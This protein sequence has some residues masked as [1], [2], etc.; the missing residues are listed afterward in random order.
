VICGKQ[1]QTNGIKIKVYI[2][3][4]ENITDLEKITD[5]INNR[6]IR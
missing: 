5:N 4:D 3:Y 6:A 2:T 1:K